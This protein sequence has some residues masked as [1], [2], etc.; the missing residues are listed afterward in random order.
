MRQRLFRLLA[1]FPLSRSVG[2]RR[3]VAGGVSRPIS[4][5]CFS[6]RC[7]RT[8]STGPRARAKGEVHMDR[9]EESKSQRGRETALMIARQAGRAIALHCLHKAA[10]AW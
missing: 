5:R 6:V 2:I 9:T 4:V 10:A 8:E 1:R 3:R 7:N